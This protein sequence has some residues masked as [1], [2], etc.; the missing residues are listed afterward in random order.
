VANFIGE[1]NFLDGEIQKRKGSAAS[2]KLKSGAVVEAGLPEGQVSGGKVTVVVRPEHARL[3]AGG[4][5]ATL[6]GTLENAVY[7]GTDTHYHIRLKDGGG[8]IV[9]RQ[10]AK[11]GSGDPQIGSAIGVA[12]DDGA[13][14]VLRD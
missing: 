1:T 6:V 8:F 11:A 12:F 2:V 7:F 13:A 9:R 3:I 14:Q 10:N 5:S 4:K